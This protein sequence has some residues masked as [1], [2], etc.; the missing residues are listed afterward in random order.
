VPAF[1]T[2]KKTTM[3][4]RM[5]R[6]NIILSIIISCFFVL[7]V[8]SAFSQEK[9]ANPK[10]AEEKAGIEIKADEKAIDDGLKDMLRD[11][12]D[13]TKLWVDLSGKLYIEWA[14]LNGFNNTGAEW[15]K[16]YRWGV[17]LSNPYSPT[18]ALPSNYSRKNHN[19][20]RMQR[21]YITIKKRIGEI[22]SVKITADINPTGRDY[23]MLKYA[24][25]QFYKDFGL[26]ALRAK[27]GKIGTP[28]IGLTDSLNDMRWLGKNYLEA[29]NLILN[30]KS[31]DNPADF[32]GL[33]SLN[34]M[35]L[36]TVYYSYTNGEGYAFD[37][38][39]S[40]DGKSHS[41]VLSVN[42][43]EIMREAYLN[44][45][46]RW[47]DINKHE[48]IYDQNSSASPIKY[49]GVTSRS[50]IGMG[51]A[52]KSDLIKAG[53]NFFMPEKKY[54][55]QLYPIVYPLT[56]I[57]QLDNNYKPG[58]REKFMLVD[59]WLN[60]NIGAVTAAPVLITGRFAWGKEMGSL[61]GNYH[62]SHETLL[63]AAGLGYQFSK[64]FRLMGYYEYS[65]YTVAG[66]YHD[67]TRKDPAPN[68][69]VYVKTEVKF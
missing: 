6:L 53:V 36:A 22:F 34:I 31:F 32:G 44:F 68:H 5:N 48:L 17:N 27:F 64:Y 58:Y 47:E 37:N 46:G 30:G 10:K 59:S 8:P 45:Y 41:L 15:S 61:L 63:A 67:P 7:S 69:N 50:Y 18:G 66:K 38:S 1:P 39:E 33:V 4:A 29:S 40:Y 19:T 20:F 65:R 2:A 49:Q 13:L 11:E 52:W 16:S 23:V 9:K 21:G 14:Y 57:S 26:V 28:V 60:I 12:K 25:V 51:A 24:Y 54:A 43:K 62:Q 3:E 35:K 55:K 42:P 56:A